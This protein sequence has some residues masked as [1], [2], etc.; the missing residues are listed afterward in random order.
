L[1]TSI[2]M[3]VINGLAEVADDAFV[4]SA[5]PGRVIRICGDEVRR[6]RLSRKRQAPVE[7]NSGHSGHLHVRDPWDVGSH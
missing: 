5:I 2:E 1:K 7:F 6:N 4:E 3:I